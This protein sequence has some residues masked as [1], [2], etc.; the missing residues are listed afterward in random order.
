M[1]KHVTIISIGGSNHQDITKIPS[2]LTD[3]TQKSIT[4]GNEQYLPDAFM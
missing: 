3:E 1:E 2:F 4:C